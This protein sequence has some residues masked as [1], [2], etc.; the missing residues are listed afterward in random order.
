MEIVSAF[1]TADTVAALVL[2]DVALAHVSVVAGLSREVAV[3]PCFDGVSLADDL[4]HS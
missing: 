3:E 1:E 4:K 2:V